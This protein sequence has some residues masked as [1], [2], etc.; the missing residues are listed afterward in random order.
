MDHHLDH[1]EDLPAELPRD[2]CRPRH[3][4]RRLRGGHDRPLRAAHARAALRHARHGRPGE[5]HRRGRRP[6]AARPPHGHRH[7]RRPGRLQHGLD[8]RA[9][10]PSSGRAPARARRALGGPPRARPTSR[11]WTTSGPGRGA[12]A[13]RRSA[14]L[15]AL[16]GAVETLPTASRAGIGSSSSARS[17]IGPSPTRWPGWRDH[18]VPAREVHFLWD[19]STAALR[20][21]PRRRD[22]SVLRELVAAR[23]DA[24]VC[25]MVHAWNV[26]VQGAVDIQSWEQFEEL[27]DGLAEVR[28]RGGA[29][30]S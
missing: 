18:G 2:R 20:R 6:T 21:L 15:P 12:T 9:T 16:P 27:V 14:T 7:G 29:G 3:P 4:G 5:R 28:R 19:K 30:A 10:T 22:A 13:A 24:T 26:P 25:R 23:P 1:P 8:G 11:T 17:S